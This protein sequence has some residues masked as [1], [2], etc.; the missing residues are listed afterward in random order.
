MTE[1]FKGDSAYCINCTGDVVVGDRIRFSRTKFSGSFRNAK[2]AGYD[3]ITATVIKDSYG[4]AKQQHTFT[5]LLND[6]TKIL[7]K[8]RNV[9]AN[10]CYRLLWEDESQRLIACDEKHERGFEARCARRRRQELAGY[11]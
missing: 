1:V 7:I 5:L 3:L 6:G 11:Y 10:S 9:Y 2:F 4:A 8:G